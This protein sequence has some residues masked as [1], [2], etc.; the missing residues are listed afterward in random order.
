[1]SITSY[2]ELKTAL[3]DW[4]DDG[5]EV[6]SFADT[7][8]DLAEAYFKQKL[9]T[10]EMETSATITLDSD[11]EGDLPSDFLEIRRVNSVTNPV[12]DLEFMTPQVL[13]ANY[14]TTTSGYPTHFTIEGDKIRVRK[15]GTSVTAY[16]Y[17]TIPALSDN[18]TTNW[19][20]DRSPLL[21]LTACEAEH[22][23]RLKDYEGYQAA[24]QRRETLMEV[25][26]TEDKGARWPNATARVKGVT[27]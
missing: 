2:S 24:V 6:S 8:I 26:M 19:L 5:S 21:Y 15:V 25:L 12:Y 20:L 3:S 9:R 22:C 14:P 18:Q 10:R 27:P 13:R 23:W 7:Y 1:M 11:G 16:Y 17:Q 4:T